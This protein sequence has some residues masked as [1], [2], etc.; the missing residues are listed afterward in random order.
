ME[1]VLVTG[2]SGFIGRQCLSLLLEKGY[3]VHGV[4]SRPLDDSSLAVHWHA[5]DL[6]DSRQTLQ[7]FADVK[8]TH[9]IHFAWCSDLGKNW[10]SLENFR[11]MQKS[12]SL[13]EAFVSHG[14]KRATIAGTCAE[15]DWSYGCCSEKTTPLD[16]ATVY[17]VCKHSLQLIMSAFARQTGLSLSWG[18]IF[19]VYGPHENPRRLVSS[20]ISSLLKPEPALCSHGEQV[21]DY[22]HVE[23]VASAFVSLLESDIQGAINIGSGNPVKLRDIILKIAD[24]LHLEK[25]VRLGA[26]PSPENDPPLVLADVKRLHNELGWRSKYDLDQ[27]LEQTIGWWQKHGMELKR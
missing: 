14:G 27:G 20:V 13:L 1:K 9:L 15:Y 21:R 6:L 8:P 22:L 16:P 11:W 3:E 12:F 24:K 4:S 10:S 5:T 25:L 17:G 19:F 2:A 26:L 18:R 23:D 7:L